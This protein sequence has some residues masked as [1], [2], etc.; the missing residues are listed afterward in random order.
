MIQLHS[1]Y[2]VKSIA[3]Y[4]KFIKYTVVDNHDIVTR[5]KGEN[6]KYWWPCVKRSVVY[7]EILD[8]YMEL[9]V[10]ERALTLIDQ[11]YGLDFYLLKN[12]YADINS[13]LG[14]KL[15][16]EMLLALA[17]QTLYPDQP[18]VRREIT[19]KYQQFMMPPEEVE[20]IGLTL[21]EAKMKQKKLEE[22][23]QPEPL[24]YEFRSQ[25]L[26]Y[27]EENPPS[28]DTRKT[29]NSDVSENEEASSSGQSWLQK[30]NPFGKKPST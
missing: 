17:N 22:L 21:D 16:R 12:A 20:W 26:E 15:K 2:A 4:V 14:F 30:F 19:T 27:L 6:A 29:G 13:V 5:Y 11:H 23:V 3:H 25:L 1:I 10:T 24:K 9:M 28:D 8:K 18:H 7:S